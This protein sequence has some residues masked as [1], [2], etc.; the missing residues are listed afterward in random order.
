MRVEC[1]ARSYRES[2]RD[3][4][5]KMNAISKRRALPLAALLAVA[6]L[7]AGSLGLR[8]DVTL[9]QKIT[10]TRGDPDLQLG[11]RTLQARGPGGRTA[12]N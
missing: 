2:T 5:T 12:V 4:E 1:T 11:T 9:E 3:E 7:P 6:L 10:V 8:A